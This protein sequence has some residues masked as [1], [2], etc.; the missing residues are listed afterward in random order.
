MC[1]WK[2]VTDYFDIKVDGAESG[3]AAWVHRNPSPA[4]E[5]IKDSVASYGHKVDIES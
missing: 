2:S 1:H 5:R 4:V 3:N